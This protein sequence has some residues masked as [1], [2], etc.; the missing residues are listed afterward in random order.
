MTNLISLPRINLPFLCT[1]AEKGLIS[2]SGISI[3]NEKNYSF[4]T[5]VEWINC[6][7]SEGNSSLSVDIDMVFFGNRSTKRFYDFF[8][9]L[10]KYHLA[11]RQVVVNWYYHAEDSYTMDYGDELS[12]LFQFPIQLYEKPLLTHFSIE[13]SEQTPHVLFDP[14]GIIVIQGPALGMEPW[15]YFHP[16]LMWLNALRFTS[17]ALDIHVEI[18][19]TQL[20]M[21]NRNYIQAIIQELDLINGKSKMGIRLTWKYSDEKIFALGD[22]ILSNTSLIHQIIQDN[23]TP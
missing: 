4:D 12:D 7:F 15:H 14:K 5:L 2:I 19:L 16:L 6:Y 3:L 13:Q 23:H 18:G 9:L 22:E 17:Q 8:A 1:D 20:D 11:G 21:L 10:E